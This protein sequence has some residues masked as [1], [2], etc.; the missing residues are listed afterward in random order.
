MSKALTASFIPAGQIRGCRE[1]KWLIHFE[2]GEGDRRVSKIFGAVA[3]KEGTGAL[4]DA[5]YDISKKTGLCVERSAPIPLIDTNIILGCKEKDI[6]NDT[7]A[8]VERSPARQVPL[9]L[10]PVSRGPEALNEA[11]ARH[12]ETRHHP[13]A[14]GARAEPALALA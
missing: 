12:S 7:W 9:E 6:R 11:L 10:I 13:I 1:D 14:Q 8:I 2:E 5:L 4:H 3:V